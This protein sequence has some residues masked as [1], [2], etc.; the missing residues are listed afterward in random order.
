MEIIHLSAECYPIAKVGGLGD[1]VGALPKYQNKLGHIAKVV[2][3]AYQTRFMQENEFEVVYDGWGKLGFQNFT[4]R[5]FREK[6]NKLGFDLFLVHIAGLLDRE[7]V[8]GY[9]DDT[10]RFLAFQIAVLDWMAQWEH[11]PDVIHCHDHHMGLIPFMASY[12]PQFRKLSQVPSILTIHNAQYQGQFGWDKLHYI[13]AFDLWKSGQLDWKGSINPLAAAIKC[14]WRVTTVSPSYLD[15]ISYKANGLEDLFAQERAKCVGILNGIDNDVWNPDTDP[16]LEKNY[17]IR[18]VDSGKKA[19]KKALCDVFNLD[20]EKPLFTFIGRLVGEK[21]ADLLPE[22]FYNALIQTNGE[23][24]ILLLGS[25]DPQVEGRLAQLKD[26]FPGSYNAYI[27]YNEILSHQVYA[28]GDFLLMPSRV[29]PCG[30]NQMYALRYGTIPIVR[31]IGGLKDT[32]ID[33]GDG[34]FGICHDQ[35]AVWD[36][37]NAIG[38]AYELFLDTKR[39]KEIRK[40]MMQL[41]HSWDKAAQQY[42]DLYRI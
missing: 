23:I 34:G 31:R 11:Q 29:E 39:V 32:V 12:C 22:I 41:D 10:E 2:M 6:T 33:I 21:G 9:D 20:P 8:Y 13:P 16:M 35:T 5:I 36:V 27:G 24:N 26:V 28:G 7:K 15:E 38:R 17:N 19:N 4:V 40:F 18:T 37:G 42:I 3:P 25:G 14:A 1:V 30:L